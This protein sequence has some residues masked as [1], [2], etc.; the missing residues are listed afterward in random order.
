MR[1]GELCIPNLEGKQTFPSEA[2]PRVREGKRAAA[3]VTREAGNSPVARP[4]RLPPAAAGDA[5]RRLRPRVAVGKEAPCGTKQ[6]F[7]CWEERLRNPGRGKAG[8]AQPGPSAASRRLRHR[9]HQARA[10]PASGGLEPQAAPGLA[11]RRGPGRERRAPERRGGGRGGRTRD[12]CGPLQRCRARPESSRRPR[13]RSYSPH[14]GET[15]KHPPPTAAAATAALTAE[16][17]ARLPHLPSRGFGV[18]TAGLGRGVARGRPAGLRLL[19][20]T[21][22]AGCGARGGWGPFLT[23]LPREEE[24]E[25]A[26]RRGDAGARGSVSSGR[27]AAD[28]RHG[29]SCRWPPQSRAPPPR[30]P[31]SAAASA[32]PP[33]AGPRCAP[34]PGGPAS[35]RPRRLRE[36]PPRGPPAAAPL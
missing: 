12:G 23:P 18:G 8:A 2:F 15:A 4:P 9:A 16:R 25:T 33:P 29:G 7:G 10:A 6:N 34:S 36:A 24:K 21:G 27:R 5:E 26:R 32:A 20:P 11:A 3:T 19:G 17:R 28:S 30:P 35:L 22:G 14:P 31:A 1:F 13:E